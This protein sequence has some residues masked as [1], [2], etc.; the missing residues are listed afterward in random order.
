[1][2]LRNNPTPYQVHIVESGAWLTRAQ[3]FRHRCFHGGDGVDNDAHDDLC[4]HVVI[5]QGDNVLCTFRVRIFENGA[6]VGQSYSAGF[7]DLTRLSAYPDPMLELGRF[8]LAADH[9]DPNLLRIALAE[10]TR[11]AEAED[12]AFL[13]GCSSFAG[14]DP[15]LYKDSFAHLAARHLAP[16]RWAPKRKWEKTYDY[17]QELAGVVPDGIAAYQAM[18]PLLRFYATMGGWVSDHAVIDEEMSTLHVFTGLE[19]AAIPPARKRLLRRDWA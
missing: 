17:G 6:G 15:T 19:I 8:C 13:F 4:R 7:Y 10:I 9:G 5:T 11:I 16:L 12:I 18:P 14:T 3:A 2:K 1:M